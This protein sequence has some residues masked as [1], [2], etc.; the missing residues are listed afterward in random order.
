MASRRTLALALCIALAGCA[1]VPVLAMTAN[2]FAEDR[3][4]CLEAGLSDFIA[5][6]V[7]PGVLYA[8]LL[9]WLTQAGAAVGTAPA[10]AQHERRDH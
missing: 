3:V 10:C 8:T 7:T 5:K 1:T 9:T 4:R 6:P 2:A